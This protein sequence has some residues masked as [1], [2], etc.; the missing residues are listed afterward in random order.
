MIAS[1][2]LFAT[3]NV[4]FWYWGMFWSVLA[5]GCG[6]FLSAPDLHSSSAWP[7]G[8]WS[9][10]YKLLRRVEYCHF[11]SCGAIASVGFREYG[12]AGCAMRVSAWLHVID[13]GSFVV[14]NDFFWSTWPGSRDSF[15]WAKLTSSMLDNMMDSLVSSLSSLPI[16]WL[17][18]SSYFIDEIGDISYLQC[19]AR[20]QIIVWQSFDGRWRFVHSFNG[21]ALSCSASWFFSE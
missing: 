5:L 21:S 15:K 1:M 11:S 2:N 8:A 7:D 4:A 9:E 18:L 16:P 3:T 12:S 13:S 10:S 20:T 6:T 14:R 17:V 19:N